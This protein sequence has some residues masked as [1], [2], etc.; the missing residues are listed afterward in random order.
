MTPAIDILPRL[1]RLHAEA[2]ALLRVALTD[3]ATAAALQGHPLGDL[4]EAA[5][6]LAWCCSEMRHRA[7]ET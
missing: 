7:G 5:R 6:R 1:E 2:N 4:Q 3:Q